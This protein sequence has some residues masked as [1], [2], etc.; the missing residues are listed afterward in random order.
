MTAPLIPPRK[1]STFASSIGAFF[2]TLVVMIPNALWAGWVGMTMWNWFIPM[3]T[4]WPNI[5]NVWLPGG[6]MTTVSL[7]TYWA[8]TTAME[9]MIGDIK[10]DLG[11]IG[12][13]V[14]RTILV[15]VLVG[16]SLLSGYFFHYMMTR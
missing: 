15:D 12:K 13:A 11:P 8:P 9:S 16:V 6:I 1:S 14:L 5:Q 4:G 3:A 10:D 2:F 7:F